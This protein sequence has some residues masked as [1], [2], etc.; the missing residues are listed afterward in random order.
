MCT[1]L[2]NLSKK[3]QVKF[4]INR[5]KIGGVILP[6]VLKNVISRKTRIKFGNVFTA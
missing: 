3:L 6:T 5:I 2:D 4:Q 1:V